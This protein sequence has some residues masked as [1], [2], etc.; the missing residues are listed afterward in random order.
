MKDGSE[1][2]GFLQSAPM[3]TLPSIRDLDYISQFVLYVSLFYLSVSAYKRTKQKGFVCWGFAA[4]GSVLHTP[5]PFQSTRGYPRSHGPSPN[6]LDPTHWVGIASNIL[7]LVGVV[8]IIRG[9][10]GLWSSRDAAGAKTSATEEKAPDSESGR[11][12]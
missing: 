10:V 5:L 2:L 9:Y 7:M 8:L 6:I 11:T 3:N 12:L 1:L 4:I